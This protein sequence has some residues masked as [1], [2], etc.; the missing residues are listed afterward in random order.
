MIWCVMKS[1]GLYI[2]FVFII[3]G[4]LFNL[5]LSGSIYSQELVTGSTRQIIQDQTELR[6]SSQDIK[7]MEDI[8]DILRSKL[9]ERNIVEN[10]SVINQSEDSYGIFSEMKVS[11]L[12]PLYI[13]EIKFCDLLVRINKGRIIT[14]FI[15]KGEDFDRVSFDS[16]DKVYVERVNKTLVILSGIVRA[17]VSASSAFATAL[18]NPDTSYVGS[19]PTAILSG[20]LAMGFHWFNDLYKYFLTRKSIFDPKD[21]SSSSS[22]WWKLFYIG[23]GVLRDVMISF[24]MMIMFSIAC[25]VGEV[26]EGGESLVQQLSVIYIQPIGYFTPLLLGAFSNSISEGMLSIADGNLLKHRIQRA[27]IRNILNPKGL[28][29]DVTRAKTTSYING[30]MISVFATSSIVLLTIPEFSSHGFLICAGMTGFGAMAI[31]IT[32]LFY[33][34]MDKRNDK[35]AECTRFF[36][37]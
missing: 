12:Y 15:N 11:F 14:E 35:M 29:Q 2:V 9:K 8:F 30:L 20:S 33:K 24:P 31:Y 5:F 23:D 37:K 36:T 22:L 1:K 34:W 10:L 21:H 27:K 18:I 32:E 26:M 19:I 17:S 13:D 7:N 25:M 28:D 4:V 3:L 16:K 6:F